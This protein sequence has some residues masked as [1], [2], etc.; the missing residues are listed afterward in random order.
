[1]SNH[2]TSSLAGLVILIKIAKAI[3]LPGLILSLFTACSSIPMISPAIETRNGFERDK[4]SNERLSAALP[5]PG[6]SD[7]SHRLIEPQ[8]QVSPRATALFRQVSAALEDRH[9]DLAEPI[10]NELIIQLPDF[11][12]LYTN[13]G[14]VYAHTSRIEMAMASLQRAVE[15]KP[16][17]CLPR[18]QIGLFERQRRSFAAAE[19]S[20]LACILVDPNYAPAHLNLGILYELYLGRLPEA[21]SAY[22]RYQS[23][24]PNK[25]VGGWVKDL[26]RRVEAGKQLVMSGVMR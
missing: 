18:V 5:A 9:Y 10:L 16:G 19:E 11:S 6:V 25:L 3:I 8:R 13:L 15:L 7:S 21:L 14:I 4:G 23:L 2:F 1:M 22:E 24:S 26:S 20:Y 12:S 17:N